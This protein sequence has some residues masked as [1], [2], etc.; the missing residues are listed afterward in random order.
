[1]S[2]RQGEFSTKIFI[3]L[4]HWGYPYAFRI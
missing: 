1:L 2:F 3:W 4:S